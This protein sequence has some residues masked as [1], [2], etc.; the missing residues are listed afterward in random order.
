MELREGET[1][2]HRGRSHWIVF[3]WAILLGLLS[4]RFMLGPTLPQVGE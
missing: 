3:G 4:A 1:I 2:I